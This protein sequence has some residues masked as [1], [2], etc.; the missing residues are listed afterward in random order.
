MYWIA[1]RLNAENINVNTPVWEFIT[2]SGA[3][4]DEEEEKD[5]NGNVYVPL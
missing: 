1:K 3:T 2:G 4:N 5:D